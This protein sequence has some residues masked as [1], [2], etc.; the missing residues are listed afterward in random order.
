LDEG[1]VQHD[2]DP[3]EARLSGLVQGVDEGAEG[4]VEA[5][6]GAQ[7][8]AGAGRPG[9]GGQ[10]AQP[11][12]AAERG[13][14]REDE[15]APPKKR[16]KQPRTPAQKAAQAENLKKAKAANKNFLKRKP[17]KTGIEQIADEVL[18][19]MMS[20]AI[21]AVK[22][23]GDAKLQWDVTRYFLDRK[24]GSTVSADKVEKDKE[25]QSN[26]LFMPTKLSRDEWSEAY[27]IPVEKG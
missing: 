6:E 7:P 22:V 26:V 1:N 4:G 15:V 2:E 25:A 11:A 21:H 12:Q 17:S 20:E 23:D 9:G 3:G 27:A 24:Y 19:K 10:E 8:S 13:L 18:S 16:R 5:S 14:H